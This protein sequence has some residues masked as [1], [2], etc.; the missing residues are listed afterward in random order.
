MNEPITD[1]ERRYL[2]AREQMVL[3]EIDKGRT[4]RAIGK[5]LGVTGCRVGQIRNIALAKLSLARI[6]EAEAK[7]YNH[8]MTKANLRAIERSIWRI[9][10]RA[11]FWRSVAKGLRRGAIPSYE[12]TISIRSASH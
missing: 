8:I 7:E 12:R 6:Q 10:K 4:L 5:D 2:S 1:Q 9:N 11:G 3:R